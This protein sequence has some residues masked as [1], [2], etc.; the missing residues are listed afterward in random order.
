MRIRV[1]PRQFHP[2]PDLAQASAARQAEALPQMTG[3]H[4]ERKKGYR[5]STHRQYRPHGVS[6]SALK[7][8]KS[9]VT[10]GQPALIANAR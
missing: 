10:R 6:R 1:D 2:Y 9:A 7:K 5:F 4:L 8:R 3:G